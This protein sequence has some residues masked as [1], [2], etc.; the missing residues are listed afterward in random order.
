MSLSYSLIT[1]IL[2]IIDDLLGLYQYM[3]IVGAIMSWLVAFNV[4]NT[5]NR[6]VQTVGDFL[7]RITEPALQ[8]IRRI[9]PMVSGIDL[10]PLALYCIIWLFRYV[11]ENQI[12]RLE[13]HMVL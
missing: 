1:G 10:S 11:I 9:L 2:H 7:Y 4:I 13:T 3:I 8:P 12:M 5:R 6:F